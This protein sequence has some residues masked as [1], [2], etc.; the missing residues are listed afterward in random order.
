[1][2]NVKSRGDDA[3]DQSNSLCLRVS[4]K[5]SSPLKVMKTDSNFVC[6]YLDDQQGLTEDRRDD[7]QAFAGG[8]KTCDAGATLSL[9]RPA[10]LE[11]QAAD[12]RR[13]TQIF[14]MKNPVK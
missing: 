3:A 12:F 10:R 7:V 5:R 2:H 14:R 1:M 13:G 6:S 4:P 9:I 8:R 11:F